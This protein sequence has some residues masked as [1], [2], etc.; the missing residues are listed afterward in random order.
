MKTLVESKAARRR[1]LENIPEPAIGINEV[2]IRIRYTG[3]A[4]S[5]GV[6]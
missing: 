4:E 3:I 6:V 5:E 1:W 2:L